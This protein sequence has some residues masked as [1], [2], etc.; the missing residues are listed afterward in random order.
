MLRQQR[1]LHRFD[2]SC[3]LSLFAKTTYIFHKSIWSF[4]GRSELLSNLD[5]FRP[6]R[7]QYPIIQ[8]CDLALLP[9]LF[10]KLQIFNV[11]Q[12]FAIPLRYNIAT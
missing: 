11:G 7:L 12:T 5:Q 9:K 2:G 3:A 8:A 10:E 4:Q 6:R 1:G